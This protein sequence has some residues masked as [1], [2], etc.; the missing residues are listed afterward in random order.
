MLEKNAVWLIT[1]CSTGLGRAL[2]QQALKAGYRVVATARDRSVLGELV[3]EHGEAV[4]AVELDVTRPDQ[5]EAAIAA[6]EARF[7]TVDVLVNNAGYGY[8]GAIEEGEDAGV[9]AMF[10]TNVFGPW[11]MIKAV[12]PGM[13]NRKTGYVVNISSVG[14]LVTYPAVGFYHMAKFALE[15]LSETLAKEVA[16]FGIG[17][18]VVE[19][20]A[21]LTD[22]RGGSAKQS[23][24]RLP[25]YADTAGKARDNVFA[26][27]GKQENDP[28]L[29]AQ[30]IIT[31]IEAA[32]PPLHLVIG[33]DALDQIRQKI[34]DL[35]RDLDTWE[36]LTRSTKFQ[37]K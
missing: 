12:L 7:G 17:V 9:R 5:I 24:I 37:K 26:A 21:F 14:G 13:R 34:V 20:G 3:K 8:F 29:G 31:A 25:A 35:K 28:V 22:F 36:D 1:G 23:N 33:G 27:H 2:A 6:S 15:G 16:P 30:A 11:N 10:E 19:P 18:T 32:L 4:L